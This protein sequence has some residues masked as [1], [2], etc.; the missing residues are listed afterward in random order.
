[1]D[2]RELMHKIIVL[3]IL[4]RYHI[5]KNAQSVGLYAGQPP[6]LEYLT[7]HGGCAQKDIANSL[8]VSPASVAVS[9]KRMEACG[10]VTRAAD[11]ADMRCNKVNIT[12]KGRDVLARFDQVCSTLDEK[13]FGT[14]SE[15]EREQLYL[16]LDRITKN[17]LDGRDEAEAVQTA[18]SERAREKAGHPDGEE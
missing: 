2:N 15:E 12:Q 17:L 13:L 10:L 14:L 9:V 5:S 16:L 8:H 3:S 7:R 6:V 18:V 1:M 4:H 11:G